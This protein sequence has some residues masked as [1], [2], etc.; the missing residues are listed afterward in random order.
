[1][2]TSDFEAS[3]VRAL[4]SHFI[5][6][7]QQVDVLSPGSGAGMSGA[8]DVVIKDHASGRTLLVELVGGTSSNSVPYATISK[9]RRLESSPL[10]SRVLLISSAVIP[11]SVVEMLRESNIEV[12]HVQGVEEGLRVVDAALARP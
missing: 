5:N 3:F 10:E 12:R 8:P 4:Q 6:S 7:E 2:K 9:L 11:L 1:M